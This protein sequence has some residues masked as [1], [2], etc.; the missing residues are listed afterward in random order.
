MLVVD[1]NDTNREVVRHYL[2]CWGME[3]SEAAGGEEA[4]ALMRAA[5]DRGHPF[6]LG[7]LDMQMPEM[8]GEALGRR[9]SDDPDLAA[10]HLVLLTSVD[11]RGE[12]TALRA[13]GFAAML[14]KPVG[15]S[16]LLDASSLP[17]TT[18]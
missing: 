9:I 1:D 4:L 2:T 8:D 11:R 6:R 10:T 16:L 15:R 14:L 13:A 17:K 18:R 3:V 12:E 7:L 5:H